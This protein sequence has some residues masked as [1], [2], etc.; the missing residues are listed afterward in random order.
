MIIA[1]T[2]KKGGGGRGW[3][4]AGIQ[5]MQ[6]AGLKYHSTST[7]W[8]AAVRLKDQARSTVCPLHVCTRAPSCS[9]S[10]DIVHCKLPDT[11]T[12]APH[13]AAVRNLVCVQLVRPTSRTS[14]SE[15]T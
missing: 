7:R 4:A 14:Q 12:H 10:A 13:K 5:R 2:F 15:V 3:G 8:S 1:D 9:D 6:P 11:E